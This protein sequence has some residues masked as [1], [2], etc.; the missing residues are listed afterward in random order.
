MPRGFPWFPL[1]VPGP[2]LWPPPSSSPS[3]WASCCWSWSRQPSQPL[4]LI[5]T[6]LHR[7]CTCAVL[8][9]LRC[10]RLSTKTTPRVAEEE[11]ATCLSYS[12]TGCG[13]LVAGRYGRGGRI[14][15]SPHLWRANGQIDSPALSWVPFSRVRVIAGKSCSS[16][17]MISIRSGGLVEVWSVV[18][19]L[20]SR[21][22]YH[23]P[24]PSYLLFSPPPLLLASVL[25]CLDCIVYVDRLSS[26]LYPHFTACPGRRGAGSSNA[27]QPATRIP[28]LEPLPRSLSVLRLTESIATG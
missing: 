2:S 10:A 16:A 13:P 18:A 24:S 8:C 17:S 7:I 27:T 21:P 19:S 3:L 15:S 11:E 25:A 12:R 9:L 4:A 1:V 20:F 14:D 5:P 23:S 28:L 6:R 22:E 26:P